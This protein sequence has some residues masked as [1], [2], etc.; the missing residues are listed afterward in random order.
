MIKIDRYI[1]TMDKREEAAIRKVI[2]DQEA[3]F[4]SLKISP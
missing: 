3:F 1:H 4:L 2:I